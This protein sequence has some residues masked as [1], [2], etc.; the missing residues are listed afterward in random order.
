MYVNVQRTPTPP[1]RPGPALSLRPLGV[2]LL[3]CVF[4]APVWA[5]ESGS[6]TLVTDYNLRGH[7]LSDGNPTIVAGVAYD[8]PSG[9]YAGAS[10][11]PARFSALGQWELA[12][13]PYFGYAHTLSPGLSWEIGVAAASYSNSSYFNY[14]EAYVGVAARNLTLRL[15]VPATHPGVGSNGPYLELNLDHALTEHIVGIC[16][17][18]VLRILPSAVG[19][20]NPPYQIDLK[21]GAVMAIENY[22]LG[23]SY[24]GNVHAASVSPDEYEQGYSLGRARNALLVSLSRVF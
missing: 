15:Y 13:L 12:V 23:V 2:L 24:V 6:L 9:W 7:S 14:D 1:A 5:E 19:P 16:H 17:G 21:V 8:A 20:G 4:C 18:G 11:A 3:G 22:S 10:V